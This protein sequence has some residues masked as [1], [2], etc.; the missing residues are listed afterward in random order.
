LQGLRERTAKQK[1]GRLAIAEPWLDLKCMM[2]GKF[3]T[4]ADQP[5]QKVSVLWL[6]CTESFCTLVALHSTF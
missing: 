4:V 5:D 6:H 3:T 1:N 2:S